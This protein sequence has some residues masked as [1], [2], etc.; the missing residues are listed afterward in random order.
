MMTTYFEMAKGGPKGENDD[1]AGLYADRKGHMLSFQNGRNADNVS[2]IAF[3]GSFSQNFV[4]NW[5]QEEVMGR[6]DP[7]ATFKNTTRTISV[8]WTVPG[9]N[10]QT[11]R[12]NLARCNKL[13]T[14]LYPGYQ[15]E[16]A[17]V[18][19]ESPIVRLKY[20]NLIQRPDTGPLLGYITSL[21]WSPILEMGFYESISGL[22][23]R[24]I[25]LSV[26]FAVLHEGRETGF[27]PSYA[28]DPGLT[29]KSQSANPF[30]ADQRS[31]GTKAGSW[32]F[33]S[34]G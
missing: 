5:N 10:W 26:E 24:A 32:P 11:A 6:M 13:I 33:G 12:D 23:P 31:A 27:Y 20:A 19:S 16:S 4:S 22:Y 34:T 1:G 3:L 7:I 28:D 14:F 8:E 25:S 30:G 17:T 15:E 18:M 29:S 2:F 9:P 21:N